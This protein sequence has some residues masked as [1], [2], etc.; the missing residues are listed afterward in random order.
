MRKKT[1]AMYIRLSIEDGD[2]DSRE[3]TES[4]SIV[5][6][7]LLLLDHIHSKSELSEY[8]VEEYCDD[9]YTG[10]NFDRPAFQR[11]MQDI[12]QKKVDCIIVKDLSR[13]GREFLDVSGYLELILPVFGTRFISVNDYFDSNDYIGTTGGV[14]L[15]FRNLI[16]AMYSK[17]LSM[18]A[19]SA[20]MTRA[21]KGEYIGG[22]PFYGYLKDPQNK[23]RLI[24]DENIR[25][26]IER[27]FAMCINGLSTT[28]IAKALNEENIL[29][30]IEYKKEKGIR[31][32]KPTLEN[33]A[34]WIPSTVRSIIKDERYAGK[35]VSNKYRSTGI[36]K[37]S[38]I[39]NNRAEWI[40][41]KGTHEGIISEEIF[42]EA[43]EALSA[44][45]KSVNKNTSWKNSGNLFVCGYCGR[46]LQK[47]RGKN[48]YL[49]C[50]KSKYHD[51]AECCSL[52]EDLQKLQSAA[53]SA[54]KAMGKTMTDGAVIIKNKKQADLQKFENA[55]ISSEKSLLKL[56]IE[57]SR[58]YES[59]KNGNLSREQFVEQQK[60]RAAEAAKIEAIIS[61][62]N[63][64]L[65]KM[66]KEQQALLTAQDEIRTAEILTKYDPETISKVVEKIL[67]YKGGRIK[68]VMKNRDCYDFLLETLS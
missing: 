15:A 17:D 63:Q 22:H 12:K 50:L 47:S 20:R 66:K 42:L 43:N 35:M 58:S 24:I 27:I 32:N 7:R 25:P 21:R 13:F 31:Y 60:I 3:K 41:V 48:I 68:L 52:H 34:L 57:K 38:Y 30:P 40:V 1:I 45:V 4:N 16:N 39:H 11:M 65:A 6:Q 59:Y 26:I 18:K 37:K 49:Y 53:F 64:E 56:R 9:G 14:E 8:K 28:M 33:K 55:I 67:V 19:K 62:A 54:I 44:R 2:L 61:A 51:N 36:G 46:R 29:C 23:H 5:N 10:T